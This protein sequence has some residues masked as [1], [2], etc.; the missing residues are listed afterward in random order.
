MAASHP[1]WVGMA[2]GDPV[3]QGTHLGREVACCVVLEN[4]PLMGDMRGLEAVVRYSIIPE[5]LG[6][7]PSEGL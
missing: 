2:Q 4:C 6:R 3:T 1:A 7:G 5:A